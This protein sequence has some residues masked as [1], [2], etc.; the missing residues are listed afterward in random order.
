M[1]YQKTKVIALFFGALGTLVVA[2]LD[3]HEF[4][5]SDEVI[6]RRP[7]DKSSLRYVRQIHRRSLENREDCDVHCDFFTC[8]PSGTTCG[9]GDKCLGCKDGTSLCAD[10]CSKNSQKCDAGRKV[11]IDS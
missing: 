7:V 6:V 11:C 3:S 10:G 2:V 4:K 1:K 5:E 8:C 9:P